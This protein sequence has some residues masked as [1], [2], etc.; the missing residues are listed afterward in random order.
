MFQIHT[1]APTAPHHLVKSAK[2]PVGF[3]Y[4]VVNLFIDLG[5]IGDGAA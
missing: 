3:C 5:I 4:T 1:A 2:G